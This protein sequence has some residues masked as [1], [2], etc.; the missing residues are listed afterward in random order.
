MRNIEASPFLEQ[1]SLVEA[2][3]AMLDSRR[4]SE[5][6]LAISIRQ[7]ETEASAEAG[8]AAGKDGAKTDA[9]ADA[10]AGANGAAK[11]AAK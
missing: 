1:P 5:F 3:A 4:V 7:P 9:K 11:G 6:T 2:K 10:K 8:G